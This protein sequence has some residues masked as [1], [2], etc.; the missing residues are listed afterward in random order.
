MNSP[1]Y[2]TNRVIFNIIKFG[3][4]P[5]LAQNCL[6]LDFSKSLVS[7][8]ISS[9]IFT[10]FSE[11]FNFFYIKYI[12]ILSWNSKNCEPLEIINVSNAIKSNL[13]IKHLNYIFILYFSYI[14]IFFFWIQ[15]VVSFHQHCHTHGS[16][17]FKIIFFL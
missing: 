5:F 1:P 14:E 15:V 11:I 13:S 17:F 8:A 10:D 6:N 3:L 16:K 2:I 7:V 4:I 12:K 9:P